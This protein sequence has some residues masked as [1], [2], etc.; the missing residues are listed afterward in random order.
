MRPD[1]PLESLT[2]VLNLVTGRRFLSNIPAIH[3]NWQNRGWET[4]IRGAIHEK[5]QNRGWE[6]GNVR[7]C[8][9]KR[10]KSWMGGGEQIRRDVN[11]TV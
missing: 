7:G 6:M 3:E 9:R 11:S 10:A 4:E 1:K 5:G 8:P 2:G